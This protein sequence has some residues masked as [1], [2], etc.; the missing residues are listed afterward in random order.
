MLHVNACK[1]K[2]CSV[3][4]SLWQAEV[5]G[6]EGSDGGGRQK[7]L[8]TGVV[9][10][11]PASHALAVSHLKALTAK[12]WSVGW[13]PSVYAAKNRFHTLWWRG[14]SWQDPHPASPFFQDSPATLFP[15]YWY[16][17]VTL[18][19]WHFTLNLCRHRT[20]RECG[21]SF[22][23]NEKL[24]QRRRKWQEKKEVIMWISRD[25][26]KKKRRKSE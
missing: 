9:H 1:A 20:G 14:I 6:G 18:A 11:H 21:I 3:Q 13:N 12:P 26:I 7:G 25:D 22:K 19:T 8:N 24:K 16:A 10:S 5:M 4:C 15:P 2:Q 23:R 17:T